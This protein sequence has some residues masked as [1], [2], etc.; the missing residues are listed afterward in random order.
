M[1]DC[2]K[3]Y[4]ERDFQHRMSVGLCLDPLGERAT[5][6]GVRRGANLMPNILATF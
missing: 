2:L 5:V 6:R 4:G 3:T 1:R